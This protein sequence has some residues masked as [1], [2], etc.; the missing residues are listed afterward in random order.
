RHT[1]PDT[2][3]SC[4]TRALPISRPRSPVRRRG[5]LTEPG[6][7]DGRRPHH[8]GPGTSEPDHLVHRPH[9]PAGHPSPPGRSGLDTD[10]PA[11]VGTDR[12]STRLNASHV[13]NS[14]AV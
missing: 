5:E 7:P 2:L 8:M 9:A 6:H 13:S 11:Q 3:P 10:A 12:K 4:P 14:Y 1:P